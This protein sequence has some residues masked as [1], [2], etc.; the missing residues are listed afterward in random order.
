MA[1]AILIVF[2]A[3]PLLGAGQRFMSRSLDPVINVRA[4]H[5]ELKQALKEARHNSP[6][7]AAAN[8]TLT[9]MLQSLP[10]NEQ[11]RVGTAAMR[12]AVQR[13]FSHRHGWVIKGFEPHEVR[14]ST[15]QLGE[16]ILSS[17]VPGYIDAIL[18]SELQNK[19][20][21]IEDVLAVV[22]SVERLIVDEI[23]GS[24]EQAYH[25]NHQ[26]THNRLNKGTLMTV[27]DSYLLVE[28]LERGQNVT[29]EE[30]NAD[31]ADILE[32]Y[33]NWESLRLFVQDLVAS[34]VTSSHFRTSNP[35]VQQQGYSFEDAV[36]IAQRISDEYGTWGNLECL[37]VQSALV[38][39]D[40]LST[41][42]VPLS[43]FYKASESGEHG[44]QESAEYLQQLGALD[45][46]SPSLGPRV[47]IANYVY[48]MSNC[49]SST[50]YYSVCCLNACETI[51]QEIETSLAKPSAKP[52]EILRVVEGLTFSADGSGGLKVPLHQRLEE[53]AAQ[54]AGEVSLH[55]RLFAQWLHY[56]FP[57]ECPYPHMSG[58][59]RP[60]TQGERMTQ[61]TSIF[62][63]TEEIEQHV[64]GTTLDQKNFAS[65]PSDDLWSWDEELLHE[66][67]PQKRLVRQ[68]AFPVPAWLIA[69]GLLV[70][71]SSL[72]KV[73]QARHHGTKVGYEYPMKKSA[74]YHV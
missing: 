27:I 28:M 41:G 64:N 60:Q 13:Y 71:V 62:A 25:L 66:P 23:S 7:S 38:E 40:P 11:G 35:F 33:P 29:E 59:V 12:Y 42:R 49:L 47:I 44:F 15:E 61:G 19:G 1:R 16:S 21:S 51:L 57:H 70:I 48:G 4:L 34:E 3:L 20:F 65:S 24:V 50:P 6:H 8:A 69:L 17:K 31:R 55:G 37:E 5:E 52:A 9:P 54:N 22:M 32:L 58:V 10:K 68:R 39:L 56:A 46:S 63:E 74:G 14:S 26:A 43:T 30:H 53:V 73:M 36:R 67:E 2:L 18:E 72:F 45:T